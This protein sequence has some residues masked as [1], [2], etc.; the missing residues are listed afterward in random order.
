MPLPDSI[1]GFEKIGTTG[2]YVYVG[3][4]EIS[5]K[6]NERPKMKVAFSYDFFLGVSEVTCGD[7]NKTMKDISGLAISCTKDSMPAADVTYYDAVL[8][9]NAKSKAAGM[10][11]A[12]TYAKATI[13][14]DKHCS[15]LEGFTFR[16]TALAFRLPTEAEWSF[17]A[18]TNWD[19]SNSWNGGTSANAAHPV[20]STPSRTRLCDMAGNVMEWVNDWLGNFGEDPVTNFAGA[21][22]GD[23]LG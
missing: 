22:E 20:C 8:Y 15:N 13:D 5:A 10:D 19:V 21:S 9:A 11:T 6:N 4:E 7:F 16:P 3:T 18:Q 14:H 23:G 17:A 1:A 2:K 12:Y